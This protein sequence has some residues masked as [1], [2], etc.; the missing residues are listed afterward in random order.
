LL[1]SDLL[2]TA[3]MVRLSLAG[4]GLL[5]TLMAFRARQDRGVG[6]GRLF[7]AAG[8]C[9]A[10]LIFGLMMLQFASYSSPS[11][12]PGTPGSSAWVY[13]SPDGE[14][15][16]TLPN[17]DWKQYQ[18][19]GQSAVAMFGSRRPE[20][21]ASVLQVKRRQTQ[22]DFQQAV[23]D[24]RARV[25]KGVQA[26]FREGKN[27]AGNEYGYLTLMES[28]PG[29]KSVFVAFAVIRCPAK[30]QVVQVL[31]EGHPTMLSEVGKASEQE[32]FEKAA[33]SICLSVE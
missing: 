8:L 29:S 14:Y 21:V 6:G 22:A 33:E 17:S 26:Q 5:L 12:P 30:Q 19:K 27:A 28:K 20:M 32:A 23:Q 2:F 25:P 15:Q 7:T 9:V 1:W 13:H 16:I 24:A 10:Q 11:G 31:F 18:P 3:G 4:V